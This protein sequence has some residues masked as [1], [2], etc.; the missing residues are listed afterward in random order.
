VSFTPKT[1]VESAQTRIAKL[2]P[3]SLEADSDKKILP[4]SFTNLQSLPGNFIENL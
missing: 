4:P 3:Q 1:G 2:G